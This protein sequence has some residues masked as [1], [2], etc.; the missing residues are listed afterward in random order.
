[1][2]F[3]DS[4]FSG[5]KVF[6]NQ[7]V[8]VVGQAVKVVLDEIDRS[9]FGQAATQLVKGVTRK[10]FSVAEDLAA[11]EQE[12]AEKYQRDGKR[13]EADKERLREIHAERERIRKEMEAAKA[14]EAAEEFKAENDKVI[15]ADMTDDELSASVGILAYK[16]CPKCGGTMR[17]RQGNYNKTYNR[18]SF[19]WQC[20]E[21]NL[22]PCPTIKLDPLQV[23][24]SVLRKE[25]PDLDGSAKH[26]QQIWTRDDVILKTHSRLRQNHLYQKDEEV[27][28]PHHVLPMK[29]VPKR[30]ADLTMLSSYEYVCMGIQ[31][32]GRACSYTVAL[33]THPQVAAMLRRREGR[34][35]IDG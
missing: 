24:A 15:A 21:E 7:L 10:Y 14:K 22:F 3:L 9:S 34:G 19:Y 32:D 2:S 8:T 18:R 26:R 33:E 20:T 29:L 4:L 5:V 1:M 23:K 6:V 35:I 12:L 30:D 28:C 31:P 16:K 11:E 27:V 25:N 13:T 17:I